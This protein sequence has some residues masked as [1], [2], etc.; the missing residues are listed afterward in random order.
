MKQTA[1]TLLYAAKRAVRARRLV[2]RYGH[3]S[4]YIPLTL[5]RLPSDCYTAEFEVCLSIEFR[6]GIRSRLNFDDVLGRA[7]WTEGG[8]LLEDVSVSTKTPLRAVMVTALFGG[9]I[10]EVPRV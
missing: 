1:R 6:P 2:N 9:D 10:H 3:Q 5:R 4:G 7:F 8:G